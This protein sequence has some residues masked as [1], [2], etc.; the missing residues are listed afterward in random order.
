MVDLWSADGIDQRNV[1]MHPASQSGRSSIS[2]SSEFPLGA[3]PSSR[4]STSAGR[5][6]NPYAFL[7][8]TQWRLARE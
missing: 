1:V 3:G 2:E 8:N 5:S 4:P 6:D 7:P